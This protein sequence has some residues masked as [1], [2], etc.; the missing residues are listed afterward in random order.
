VLKK[1]V[2]DAIAPGKSLGHIDRDYAHRGGKPVEGVGVASVAM[3]ESEGGEGQKG[4]KETVEI[5]Q[6]KEQGLQGGVK[7]L[8]KTDELC[9]DCL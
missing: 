4:K 5:V 9:M 1:L 6:L 2:R 8:G 7:E 3:A